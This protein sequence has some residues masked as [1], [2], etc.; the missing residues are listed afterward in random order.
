MEPTEHEVGHVDK[1]PVRAV[2]ARLGPGGLE[3]AIESLQDA[4]ADMT[5]EPA[6]DP[7][8]M[9]HDGVGH[10]DHRR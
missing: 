5:I 2:A 8:P 9:I 6:Q 7:I 10:L 3:Q 1:V 4:V